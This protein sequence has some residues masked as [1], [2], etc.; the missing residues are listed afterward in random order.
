MLGSHPTLRERMGECAPGEL[1][2]S[3][4]TFAEI[5]LGEQLGKSPDTMVIEAFV[6][7][8]P[9]LPFDEAAARAY[10]QLPFRRRSFDR[11]IAAHA[12][13]LELPLIT[14]NHAD[15]VD[16]PSLKLENWTR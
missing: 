4:I 12:I 2:I 9:V 8:V 7:E 15:F 3:A 10:A 6:S 14:N 11:L 13:S 5:V 1:G 16:L